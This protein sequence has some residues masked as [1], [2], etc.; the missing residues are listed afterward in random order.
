MAPTEASSK[1]GNEA[2]ER[3]KKCFARA[4]HENANEQEARA[5]AKM[6][7]KIMEQYQ[8]SQ[9]DLMLNEAAEKRERRGGISIV[10][11][12]PAK[13]GGRPFIPG[14]LEWL[15]GA[16]EIF[17][18]SRSFR[19]AKRDRIEWTFY[20]IA[21]HTVSSAIA[22]ECIHNQILDWSRELKGI[23]LRNSYCLGVAS[24]LLK[25]SKDEIKARKAQARRAEAQAFAAKVREEERKEQERLA[26]V[27]LG[28][29]GLRPIE[30]AGSD[31]DMDTDN[32][33][34][35]SAGDPN[36]DQ[37]AD[38]PD[39][40][41]DADDIPDKG[42]LPDYTEEDNTALPPLDNAADFDTEL[43]RF[44]PR[45][46]QGAEPHSS[47]RSP[48]EK[49]DSAAEKV[50]DEVDAEEEKVE[51]RSAR[52]LTKYREMSRDIAD[53]V[54]KEQNI[55]LRK[56]RKRKHV[57]K[58]EDAYKKGQ[59]DSEKIDFRTARIE[60][61]RKSHGEPMDMDMAE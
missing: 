13:D 31:I 45:E 4:N 40:D 15:S 56:S 37:P 58:D 57:V 51:W 25:L 24:G 18:D 26:L 38:G 10:D 44:L 17:F 21:E 8:I 42:V 3:V 9:A 6:A 29:L 2:I 46:R 54:L 1:V 60:P 55:K 23:G 53:S 14:W 35:S 30:E 43:Q 28:Q 61:E 39:N 47:S 7:S 41:E 5:A 11:V 59:E 34:T 33:D 49:M 52:Q 48:D 36:N 16:V 50:H 12:R 32:A 27:E 19:T 20:G 22:F